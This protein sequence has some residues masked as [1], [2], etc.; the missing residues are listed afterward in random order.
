MV[1]QVFL[2]YCDF[3]K[4]GLSWDLGYD[5]GVGLLSMALPMPWGFVAAIELEGAKT[6]GEI[7]YNHFIQL[8]NT[9][10]N[11]ENWGRLYNGEF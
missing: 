3:Q 7:F 2:W 5:I 8:N 4:N 6:F 10:Y 11:Y 1:A 9:L